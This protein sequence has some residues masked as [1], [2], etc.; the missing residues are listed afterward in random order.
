[1]RRKYLSLDV[2]SQT[3]PSGESHSTYSR[4]RA[5]TPFTACLCDCQKT[6]LKPHRPPPQLHPSRVSTQMG[7]ISQ[8]SILCT[9]QAQ[10]WIAACP[11]FDRIHRAEM[12]NFGMIG[13]HQIILLQP[14]MLRK[15]ARTRCSINKATHSLATCGTD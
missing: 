8:L 2:T 5:S 15:S 4:L 11:Q 10:C 6:S 13:R 9:S 12:A 1:M 7:H 14:G 3:T